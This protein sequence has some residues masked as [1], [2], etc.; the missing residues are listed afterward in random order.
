MSFADDAIA[1]G[2]NEIASSGF[3]T[4]FE[5]LEAVML[6]LAANALI[7]MLPGV[8]KVLFG[9]LLNALAAK[10]IDAVVHLTDEELAGIHTDALGTAKQH[11]AAAGIIEF[12]TPDS[13]TIHTLA[14]LKAKH[15]EIFK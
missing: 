13:D 5:K 4:W 6:Q 10:G 2:R 14:D 12:Q 9:G 1:A 15:P 3:R 11:L 7:A 8:V